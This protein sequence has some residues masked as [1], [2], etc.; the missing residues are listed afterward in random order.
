MLDEENNVDL[1]PDPVSSVIDGTDRSRYLGGSDMA[2]ILGHSPWRSPL[3]VQLEKLGELPPDE[4]TTDMTRGTLLEPYVAEAY[5]RRFQKEL[6]L[7][8]FVRHPIYPF[9]GGHPDRITKDGTLV[10][11]KTHIKAV[12]Y[13][14]PETDQVPDHEMVQD[15]WYA[16]LLELDES[17][18]V[19]LDLAECDWR[20]LF[21]LFLARDSEKLIVYLMEAIVRYCID[22]N[23]RLGQ[24]MVEFGAKWWLNHVEKRERVPVATPEDAALRA[25]AWADVKGKTMVATPELDAQWRKFMLLREAEA[26]VK[27]MKDRA[28]MPLL[29]AMEFAFADTLLAPDGSAVRATWKTHPEGRIDVDRLRREQPEIAR[30]YTKTSIKRPF[31][32]KGQKE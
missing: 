11:I 17:D 14:E 1:L 9:L 25:L 29:D 21:N 12:G 13:G 4:A 28:K 32:P 27:A 7:P 19:L 23:R 5:A 6:I 15:Q 20:E 22:R 10:E 2:A 30:K 18:L 3:Q 31:N 24:H 26:R 16:E 8:P